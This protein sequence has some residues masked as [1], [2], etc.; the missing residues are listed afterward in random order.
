MRQ[1]NAYLPGSNQ[2]QA[3]ALTEFEE[4]VV[5]ND[6]QPV[7]VALADEA[8]AAGH[9]PEG[10][11][12]Q[13]VYVDFQKNVAYPADLGPHEDLIPHAVLEVNFHLSGL[14][15]YPSREARTAAKGVLQQALAST[16]LA[17]QLSACLRTRRGDRALTV[18]SEVIEDSV[19]S[20]AT[21][22][23]SR[24]VLLRALEAFCEELQR[25]PQAALLNTPIP[26]PECLFN[27]ELSQASPR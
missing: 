12:G 11:R 2:H 8:L 18:A 24:Q 22:A 6:D 16:H 14:G 9:T 5:L 3:G 19:P 25:Q 20:A 23:Q 17:E 15:S 4:L 26:E 1:P 27:E 21:A 7:G 10:L 13:V